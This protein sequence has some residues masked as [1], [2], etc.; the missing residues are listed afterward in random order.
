MIH[1]QAKGDTINIDKGDDPVDIKIGDT[2][3]VEKNG[4]LCVDDMGDNY[5]AILQDNNGDRFIFDG[6][7]LHP[8]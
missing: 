8:Y 5:S 3:I 6:D 1:I 7:E 2:V 4:Y